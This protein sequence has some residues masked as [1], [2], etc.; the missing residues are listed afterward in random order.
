MARECSHTLYEWERYNEV[1]IAGE[2]HRYN[3]GYRSLIVHRLDDLKCYPQI[4]ETALKTAVWYSGYNEAWYLANGQ[5]LQ[6]PHK[7]R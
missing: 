7:L 5:K 6:L 3:D 2:V 1:E 4:P